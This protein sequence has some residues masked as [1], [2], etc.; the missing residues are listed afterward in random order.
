MVQRTSWANRSRRFHLGEALAVGAGFVWV[1]TQERA[2]AVYRVE[3]ATG[4]LVEEPWGTRDTGPLVVAHSSLWIADFLDGTVARIDQSSGEKL[5]EIRV[6]E[7]TPAGSGPPTYTSL[8]GA[9]LN[10]LATDAT[11]VWV[12]TSEAIEVV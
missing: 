4:S 8:E 10:G 5:A 3:P 1:T 2:Q 6:S 12:L 11:G 7:A 9:H